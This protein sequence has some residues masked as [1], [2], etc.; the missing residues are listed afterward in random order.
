MSYVVDNLSNT[1]KEKLKKA[2]CNCDCEKESKN[3]KTQEKFQQYEN[4]SPSES[5]MVNNQIENIQRSTDELFYQINANNQLAEYQS[6]IYTSFES[7]NYWLLI[8]YYL[9]FIYISVNI[10]KDYINGSER[11]VTYDIALVL[12]IFVFPFVINS[13]EAIIYNKLM[14]VLQ[15]IAYFFL[16]ILNRDNYDFNSMNPLSINSDFTE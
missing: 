1:L 12:G 5:N 14:Y 7:L 3:R 6:G 13:T 2:L 11:D 8:I 10:L 16:S 9:L 4:F 15:T